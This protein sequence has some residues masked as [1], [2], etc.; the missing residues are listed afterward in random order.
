MIKIQIYILREKS[1]TYIGEYDVPAVPALNHLISIGTRAK[2]KVIYIEWI[3][4]GPM[5]KGFNWI[6][7]YVKSV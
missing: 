4:N 5:C 7:V 3:I 2:Y 1:S 6:D